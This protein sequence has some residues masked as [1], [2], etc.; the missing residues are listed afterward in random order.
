MRLG[1]V[2][3]KWRLEQVAEAGAQDLAIAFGE[4]G[5]RDSRKVGFEAARDFLDGGLVQLEVQGPDVT[6][7]AAETAQGA[8]RVALVEGLNR[9]LQAFA[10][11]G[12]GNG[13]S[14]LGIERL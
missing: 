8:S 10:D 13:T 4:T 9:L 5:R 6:A 3:G 7:G 1:F 2:R 12:L 11:E 14:D